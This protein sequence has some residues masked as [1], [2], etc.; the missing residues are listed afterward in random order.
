MNMPMQQKQFSIGVDIGGTHI[1]CVAVDLHRA[2][3]LEHTHARATY[4]HES[5]AEHILK[6]WADALNHSCASIEGPSLAGIG[7]A[8]PGPFDYRKGVS[9]MEHKFKNLFGLHIPTA[10]GPFLG[11][12]ARLPMRFIN[13][14]SAFAIGESWQ[15][16]GRGFSKVVVITLGT[17]FGSAFAEDGVPVVE[18]DRV[19]KEGCLWH[20]PFQDGIA[21]EYFSTRWFEREYLQQTGQH[22]SGVKALMDRNGSDTVVQQ[23]FRRFGE[24]LSDCLASPLLTFGA[25]VLVIGGNISHALPLFGPALHEGFARAGVS[26][27][28]AVSKLK[29]R[30]ALLGSARLLE[31][32]FWARAS[33]RLPN[34]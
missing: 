6:A 1:S 24:N 27:K 25:E 16:E 23:L 17:G 4:D 33:E 32:V 18:G 13:D 8:I 22:I 30:A 14:A 3:V 26:T 11:E 19:P 34:F 20:L 10:I 2:V 28:V 5:P 29:E 7:M 12:N 31:D 9:N 15:G 21:D